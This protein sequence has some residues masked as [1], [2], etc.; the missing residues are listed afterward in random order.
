[1]YAVCCASCGAA[2]GVVP[3]YNTADRIDQ[4]ATKLGVKMD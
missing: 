1:M 4:L 2:V 3:F